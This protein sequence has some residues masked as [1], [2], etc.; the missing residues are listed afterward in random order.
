MFELHPTLAADTFF[1][2]SLELCDVLLNNNSSYSWLVLVPRREHTHEI[3]ELS[4]T[5]QQR[6]TQETSWVSQ[7][8]AQHS[9]AIKMNI[10]AFGNQVP[11]LHVH[12]IARHTTDPAWP[13]PVWLNLQPTPYDNKKAQ[14]LIQALRLRLKLK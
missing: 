3:H 9:D 10:A 6:L 7:Q 11:Q 5:D 2:G 12:I 1:V 14:D 13:Q 4:P 8:L